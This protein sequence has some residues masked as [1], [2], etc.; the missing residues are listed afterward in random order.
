MAGEKEERRNALNDERGIS[1]EEIQE[2][3]E[4]ERE[5]DSVCARVAKMII[6]FELQRGKKNGGF[7]K[8]PS[9]LFFFSRKKR[10]SQWKK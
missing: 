2:K 5:R 6:S 3:R 4:R 8:V 9:I 1:V 7:F 10:I